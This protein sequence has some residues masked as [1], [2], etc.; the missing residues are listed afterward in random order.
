MLVLEKTGSCYAV[1][2]KN[3]FAVEYVRLQRNKWLHI[4]PVELQLLQ[5][6][7]KK[8]TCRVNLSV[9]VIILLFPH[10]C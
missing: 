8:Q 5:L 2:G 9:L 7:D 10:L 3:L 4:F 6:P 1:C